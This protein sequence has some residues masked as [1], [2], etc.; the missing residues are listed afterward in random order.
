MNYKEY[1]EQMKNLQI[2]LG[3]FLE[4]FD[5]VE[6]NYIKLKKI[7]LDNKIPEN[8]IK[9]KTFLFL[10]RSIAKNHNRRN[11]LIEKVERIINEY[12][13][14]IKHTLSNSELFEIFKNQKLILL[15]LLEEKI[16]T[17][18][19]PI[20]DTIT[21]GK[22]IKMKYPE[23]FQPEISEFLGEKLE[24]PAKFEGQRK[25]GENENYI[26]QL[27]RQDSI[28][29]FISFISKTNLSIGFQIESSIN[30]TNS[31]LIRE[32]PTLIEYSAFFGSIQIFKYL[33][34]NKAPFSN[35]L[36]IYA[37]HSNNFEL[38]SFLE[39]Q[40]IVP[41]YEEIFKKS[42]EC[43]HN[44][45]AN[46]IFNKF[47]QNVDEN[48]YHYNMYNYSFHYRNYLYFPSKHSYKFLFYYACQYNHLDIVEN[49]VKN[50]KINVDKKIVSSSII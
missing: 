24:I 33:L 36:W 47:I 40:Q 9:F 2:N 13:T 39:I 16:I 27:M 28:E 19:Q 37:I 11:N 6:E 26:C 21:H 7:I 46:Y 3:K 8:R 1:I 41:L 18:D 5:N 15:F 29:E 30:E 42:I 12:K 10:L 50:T 22:Y 32:K 38:I 48:N 4:E 45:I 44:N 31:F 43:H 34:E 49:L 23:Y 14:N 25:E 17:I 35:K 20:L